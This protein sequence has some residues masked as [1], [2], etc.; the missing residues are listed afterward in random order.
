MAVEDRRAKNI[1][2]VV[3]KFARHERRRTG[4]GSCRRLGERRG[5][6]GLA[7]ALQEGRSWQ[8]AH[9]A[10][11]AGNFNSFTNGSGNSRYYA[12]KHPR[13]GAVRV[14]KAERAHR[15]IAG[16]R[17]ERARGWGVS[18]LCLRLLKNAVYRSPTSLFMHESCVS[19]YHI[20]TVGENNRKKR[21]IARFLAVEENQNTRWA[22]GDFLV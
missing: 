9:F 12:Q 10:F 6:G 13:K 16:R 20:C 14:S 18:A 11:H 17:R 3:G 22:W 19:R 5:R 7:E 8:V 21:T 15:E 4:D 1:A 2:V